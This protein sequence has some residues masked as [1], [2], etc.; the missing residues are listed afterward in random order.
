MEAVK[1]SGGRCSGALDPTYTC[2]SEWGKW[3]LVVVIEMMEGVK[4]QAGIDHWGDRGSK[5]GCLVQKF[6]RSRHGSLE[7]PCTLLFTHP[8][9]LFCGKVSDPLPPP[10]LSLP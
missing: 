10:P 6:V 4:V 3:G 5:D 7:A 1:V 8:G 9:S 2:G